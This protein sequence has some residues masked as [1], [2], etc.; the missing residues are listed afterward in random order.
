MPTSKPAKKKAPRM[1]SGYLV[2]IRP[3]TRHGW[4]LVV[5][6]RASARDEASMADVGDKVRITRV[7]VREVAPAKKRRGRK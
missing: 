4:W 1:R 5:D 7:I 6:S 2:E 3:D